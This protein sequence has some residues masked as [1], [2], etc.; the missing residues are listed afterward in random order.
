VIVY[1]GAVRVDS[2]DLSLL[3]WGASPDADLLYRGLACGGPRSAGQLARDLNLAP[4][5]TALALEE[6][7]DLGAAGRL[8]P[9]T[10]QRRVPLWYALPSA[11][12]AAS[13]HRRRARTAGPAQR[14]EQARRW[15]A[16]ARGLGLPADP[17]D[18]GG[19]AHLWQG[20]QAARRRIA[21]LNAAERH[22]HLAMNPESAFSAEV[23]AAAAPLDRSLLA[24]GV[25]MRVIGVP[26]EDGAG[27]PLPD[28]ELSR[29]GGEYREQLVVPTKLII[30][31]RRIALLPLDP[32]DPGR[33]A[34]EI[35]HP[36]TVESLLR[37]F[38]Q[39]WDQAASPRPE[40][41]SAIQLSTRERALVALLAQGHTDVSAAH[42]LHISPRLVTYLV[43]SLMDRLGVN[44]R[45]Q[46]G[47]ALGAM[48]VT[49]PS[50][51]RRILS[52]EPTESD[53]EERS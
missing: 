25:R 41:V 31:D 49:P 3:R 46:L 52:A 43:R 13:L 2:A 44:N 7:A 23:A 48:N 51:A 17:A 37:L 28:H 8:S 32:L 6:L 1:G 11:T 19:Q 10:A 34:L 29:H 50:A 45:F 22:E 21:E 27:S 47:L 12:V 36:A 4:R 39:Q 26:A 42:V 33:G 30:V 53:E 5:R 24:R 35:W 16:L 15:L 18:L 40:G 38:F 20:R 9:R 14:V